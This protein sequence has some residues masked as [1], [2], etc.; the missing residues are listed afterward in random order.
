MYNRIRT[1]FSILS[2]ICLAAIVPLAIFGGWAAFLIDLAVAALLF[3][4]VLYCKKKQDLLDNPPD[5]QP[6]YLHPQPLSSAEENKEDPV[7]KE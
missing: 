6:D 2:A 1:I 4:P 7:Q 5:R 3:L